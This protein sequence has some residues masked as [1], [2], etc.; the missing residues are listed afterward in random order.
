MLC[1]SMAFVQLN[2]KN[3]AYLEYIETYYPIAVTEMN[4]V[5]IPASIKLAQGILE[6]NA[7][8]SYLAVEANNHFGIKCGN[9]W[10]G[11]KKFREDDDY[12]KKGNLRKSCFRAFPS[13][14]DSYYA[15]SQFLKDPNKVYRY[16]FLF[17]YGSQDYISWAKGLQRSGYATNPQYSKL[18][19]NLIET[20]ELWQYDNPMYENIKPSPGSQVFTYAVNGAQVMEAIQG[21]TPNSIADRSGVDLSR[22]LR[23]NKELFAPGQQLNKGYRVYLQGKR[24]R[25]M[26]KKK[27]HIVRVNE[28]IFDISQNYGI[29]EAALRKRN[30]M[31][32]YTE[33]KAGEYIYLS[34]KRSKKDKIKI[35][36]PD[37]KRT[38][39][40]SEEQ[41]PQE[42]EVKEQE[43]KEQPSG[44]FAGVTGEHLDFYI[45]PRGNFRP[46]GANNAGQVNLTI[47][48]EA[49]QTMVQQEP[50]QEEESKM[51][52]ETPPARAR[53]EE[54]NQQ[55]YYTVNQGDTLYKISR[56]YDMTVIRLKELNEM[57]GD[58][59]AVGQKI[60]VQ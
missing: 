49:P 39:K 47:N 29:Q 48:I 12:D 4:R 27:L 31:D 25:N 28:S 40:K 9:S 5:G 51:E 24:T 43:L 3:T 6:S 53:K 19:I 42:K 41:V 11:K 50:Q 21:D 36:V 37:R 57:N 13:V 22:I 46:R 59:L 38:H 60:R 52:K 8:R 1:A 56:M 44:D 32:D 45:Q 16:G 17:E 2:A 15:H 20:Y 7:G 23:Y 30:R 26:S 55:Q 33:P 58:L 35:V 54:I 18:L 14:E 10:N 34:G